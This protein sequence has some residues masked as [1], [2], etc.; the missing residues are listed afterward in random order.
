MNIRR[1]PKYMYVYIYCLLNDKKSQ[2]LKPGGQK[3]LRL[4]SRTPRIPF[5]VLSRTLYM[6]FIERQKKHQYF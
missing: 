5:N 1:K 6:L 4:S 2:V 3:T